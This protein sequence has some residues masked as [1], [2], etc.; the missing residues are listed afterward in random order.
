ML[1]ISI[2]EHDMSMRLF[3]S[4]NFT[5]NCISLESLYKTLCFYSVSICSFLV[6]GNMTDFCLMIFILQ[7]CWTDFIFYY[8]N[9]LTYTSV[10]LLGISLKFSRNAVMSSENRD[11]FISSFL[12]FAFYV[13]ILPYC[14]G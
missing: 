1:I 6:V 14:S 12:T 8:L 2:H 4:F 13:F 3:R 9:I 11:G 5:S 10:L 7:P